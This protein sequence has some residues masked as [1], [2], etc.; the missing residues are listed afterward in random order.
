LDSFT[1]QLGNDTLAWHEDPNTNPS[2]SGISAV[3]SSPA[4]APDGKVYV[5]TAG[6]QGTSSPSGSGR[7]VCFS[8]G[9]SGNSFWPNFRG[10]QFNTGN[11]QDN[12]WTTNTTPSLSITALLSP[13]TPDVPQAYGV[14]N[15][16]IAVGFRTYPSSPSSYYGPCNWSTTP[17]VS[18]NY[19]N[20]MT[21]I[22]PGDPNFVYGVSDANQ[23]AGVER[24]T[25]TWRAVMWTN[26]TPYI[27]PK[28]LPLPT[29]FSSSSDAYQISEA[30]SAMDIKQAVVIRWGTQF[31]LSHNL[32]PRNN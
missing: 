6:N 20:F 24:Y 4:V 11:V 26:I 25:N 1:T 30:R 27:I 2:L 18:G 23:A 21:E 14:N 17:N 22:Y 10:N 15:A 29:G 31:E 12:K 19:P 3:F 9:I 5:A 32:T 7:V 28:L 8:T 16:G 13:F